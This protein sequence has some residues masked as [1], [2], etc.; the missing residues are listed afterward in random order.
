MLRRA[1]PRQMKMAFVT[2]DEL[3]P[4]TH[5]L[6]DLDRLVSFDFIYDKISDLYSST[7]R[8]SVDPVVLIKM[9]LIGYLYGIDSERRLEQEIT[10]N[11]A[12]RWFLGIDL[13]ERVPDHSTISQ[14]RR[15]KFDGTT[16]FRDIF[17]EI[18]RKCIE[19]GLVSGK[20]LMTDS[21]HIKANASNEM[22]EIIE[23]PDTPTEYMQKLDREAYELGLIKEP[24]EYDTS[25]TKTVT[26]ST[27]DPECGMMKRPGKPVGFHYLDH[28]TCDSENGIIT[29]VYVTAGNEHDSTPHTQ[30][31]EY[32]IDKFDMKT[33]AICADA[34]YDSGE[35]HNAM[36]NR[37]IKTFIPERTRS[38]TP[39]Y[40]PDFDPREFTYNEEQ[41]IYICPAGK[42]L[43]Y[44]SY[45]KK[46]RRKRYSAKSQDCSSCPYRER[47]NGQTTYPRRI[48]RT[49]HEKARLIQRQNIDTPE[50]R[51]A[52]RLRKIWCEGNFSHQKANHNLTRTRK[53][54][55]ERVTEQ[56]LLSACALNLKRLVKC[57]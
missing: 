44:S 48:E 22:R 11:I 35:V 21:T 31:L 18:V 14:L 5:F 16:V 3:M 55:I 29:D 45:R 27:T 34:G 38:G 23:V 10:V 57:L 33:E 56:C 1:E 24:I 42:E 25:K 26:K 19:T 4:E 40:E 39:N 6:R 2:L 50:Y 52:M 12:Y 47:C 7:G 8:P 30:R 51:A 49:L 15:R 20:L 13:D 17:D 32:Q 53:R 41:D 37:N 9:L 46:D 36:L 54:G 43:H 28:Q